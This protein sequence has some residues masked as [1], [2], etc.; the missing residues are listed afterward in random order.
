MDRSTHL[1]FVLS[2]SEDQ[3][4]PLIVESLGHNRDQEKV[5]RPQGYPVYHWIQTERGEGK[6][7]FEN[8]T[9]SLA[10]GSGVLL[11]PHAAHR[12]EASGGARW[13]TFYLTFGGPAAEA[14]LQSLDM[15]RSA[16]YEWEDETPFTLQKEHMISRD[17]AGEDVFG[18]HLS[19]DTYRF[20]VMLGKYGQLHNNAP[21]SRNVEKLRPLIDW[22]EGHLNDAD[23]GLPELAAV[24]G[25]SPRHLNGLFRQTFSQSPYAYF[26][27]LR[28][29]K[30]KELLV[31]HPSVPVRHIGEKV[32]FRDPSHFVATFRRSAGMTPEQFRQLH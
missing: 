30:A 1:R 32:G 11:L 28:I 5:D 15:N 10:P 20:L 4:L 19:A 8:K 2:P 29:R 7:E 22:M 3:P 27:S 31:M 23:I 17:N 12:Y 18:L 14:I 13:E 16:Y 21:I 9:I 6:I 26:I 25:V 24:L